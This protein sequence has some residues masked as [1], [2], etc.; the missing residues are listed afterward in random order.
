MNRRPGHREW[1]GPLSLVFCVLLVVVPIV[2]TIIVSFSPDASN[3]SLF[4]GITTEWYAR[5]WLLLLPK[6][7]PTLTVTSMVL[8]GAMIVVF[9]LCHAL[10]R[11]LVPGGAVIRQITMLPLAVPGVALGLALAAS[12]PA[13]RSSGVLLVVGQLLITVPF[14]VAGLVPALAD[15]DLVEAERVAATLGAGPIRR[16][17]TITLP[18]IRLSLAA[19]L[20]MAAA[21]SIGEFNLS[22]FVV[23]PAYQTAPFALFSAFLTQRVE[24]GAA[25]SMLFGV[26]L[27]P[28]AIV[29]AML[30]R[31]SLSRKE[32]S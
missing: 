24:V 11:R 30:A 7:G 31:S 19:A 20:L 15:P 6:I 28:A 9:P 8:V 23:S 14:L 1:I 3:M 27:L 4:G 18:S 13:L 22:F 25:G 29:A 10:A 16:L 21:L 12:D 2:A 5:A 26:A 17:L 32:T